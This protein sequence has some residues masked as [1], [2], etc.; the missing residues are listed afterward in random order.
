MPTF[1]TT[2]YTSLYVNHTYLPACPKKDGAGIHHQ[3]KYKKRESNYDKDKDLETGT[4]QTQTFPS[5]ISRRPSMRFSGH[6][7]TERLQT[8]HKAVARSIQ[9][10]PIYLHI[11]PTNWSHNQPL[12]MILSHAKT[13][14]TH[15]QKKKSSPENIPAAI[16]S[17]AGRRE[18]VLGG[19]APVNGPGRRRCLLHLDDI[20]HLRHAS[21]F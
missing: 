2:S 11:K 7:S 9:S 8:Q 13:R 15:T 17:G 1:R 4:K 10:N 20:L 21:Q 6:L 16:Q 3:K 5:T 18:T 14:G 12:P 19:D